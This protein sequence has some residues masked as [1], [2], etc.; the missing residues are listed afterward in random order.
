MVRR[1]WV[2]A[3]TVAAL[4]VTALAPAALVPTGAVA[5]PPIGLVGFSDIARTQANAAATVRVPPGSSAYVARYTLAP[6]TGIS[7]RTLPGVAILSVLDGTLRVVRPNCRWT[8]AGAGLSSVL[9]P[10]TYLLGN[11]GKTPVEFVGVFV[12]LRK[13]AVPPLAAPGP[14]R[15]PA[16]CPVAP[17]WTDP[18]AAGLFVTDI[19]RGAFSGPAVGAANRRQV[20]KGDGILALKQGRDILITTYFAAPGASSGWISHYPA[21]T[22]VNRGV[23][24]YY[25]QVDD[26]CARRGEFR[27]GDAFGRADGHK[28]LTANEGDETVVLTSVY[29]NIPHRGAYLP[30][31]NH[32]EAIDF[33]E[34]PPLECR[35][36]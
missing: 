31:G 2:K 1:A 22:F 28:V 25:E 8:K 33:S 3:A 13:G 32:L 20:R 35:R 11:G 5:S 6:G 14:K 23:L 19:A 4:A 21:L 36:L 15:P 9:S 27:P 10:G 30:A 12:G 18:T 26:G 17:G 34:F 29:V 24:S 7:W 16:V